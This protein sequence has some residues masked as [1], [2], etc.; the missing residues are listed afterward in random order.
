MLYFIQV[1]LSWFCFYALY[2]LLYKQ[3][4]FFQLNRF[5]LLFT[6]LLGCLLPFDWSIMRPINPEN[7]A[8][9]AAT[10]EPIVIGSKTTNKTLNQWSFNFGNLILSVY[11]IGVL[12]FAL[13][14]IIG[15]WRIKRIISKSQ[16][17]DNQ[18]FKLVKTSKTHLPFSFFNYIF[19]GDVALST[20]EAAEMIMQHELAHVKQKHSLDIIFI[21][22]LQIFFWCSPMIYLYKKSLKTV[23]EYLADEATVLDFSKKAYG[24]VLLGQAKTGY[25]LALVHPFHSQ[26]KLRF[27]MLLKKHSSNW[28]YLKYTLCLPMLLT[29]SILLKAQ[30]MPITMIENGYEVKNYSDFKTL[31]SIDTITLVDF[32]TSKQEVKIVKHQDTVYF[33]TDKVATFR[34]GNDALFKFLIETIKYPEN[35]K[36]QG[37]EGK[38][39]V[40]FTVSKEGYTNAT[41]ASV[42]RSAGNK[43]LDDEAIRVVQALAQKEVAETKPS[44]IAGEK[45]GKPVSTEFTLPLAFKLEDKDKKAMPDKQ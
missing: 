45:N 23:H 43:E 37:A 20:N 25:S 24:Y 5:Y 4:T 15:L 10:L 31:S 36:K 42:K 22:L 32:E 34:G 16:I 18:Y 28:A 39:F 1:T 40:K 8:N 13:R 33:K 12:I 26:L 6:L 11:I 27:A 7:I 44:W 30:D 14:F 41:S 38:V 19:V 3:E 9:L 35:A 17:L 21:E 29:I 2:Q